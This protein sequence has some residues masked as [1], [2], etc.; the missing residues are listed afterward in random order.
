M[1]QN[2]YDQEEFFEGYS[3]LSRSQHGLLPLGAPEWPVLRSFIPPLLHK[4][5]LDLGCGMG[6][7]CRWAAEQGANSVRGLDISTKMLD[8]AR[9]TTEN[10][11]ISYEQADLE[12]MSLPDGTYDVVFSSL[13]LH[14]IVNLRGL[15]SQIHASLKPGGT[16]VFSVEH[17]TASAPRAADPKWI[18]DKEGRN[19][20]PLNGYLDEGERRKTWFI[21]R[22]V[23][24][25]RTIARYVKML[26]SAGFVLRGIEEWGVSLEQIQSGECDWVRTRDRTVYLLVKAVKAAKPV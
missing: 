9:N 18:V 25:H 12:N 1:A 11:A 21:E 4:D 13:A 3:G 19:T 8:V 15:M 6:W 22:V 14:Y 16:F 2:I 7:Y 17:P 20:W 24:Q 10:P 26:I 5:F 23:R